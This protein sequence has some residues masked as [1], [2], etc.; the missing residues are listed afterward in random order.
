MRRKLNA[1]WTKS[2]KMSGSELHS[3]RKRANK[4]VYSVRKQSG[5]ES[6]SAQLQGKTLRERRQGS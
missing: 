6:E 4:N 5:K 3:K 2:E 1:S